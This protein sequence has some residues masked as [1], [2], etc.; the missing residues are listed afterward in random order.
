MC[1]INCLFY[2]YIDTC[3]FVYFIVH[4]SINRPG[5]SEVGGGGGG[6]GVGRVSGGRGGMGGGTSSSYG[7]PYSRVRL[8]Y[9][10]DC[11]SSFPPVTTRRYKEN[12][13]FVSYPH[14]KRRESLLQIQI[15]SPPLP[16]PAVPET[17]R[18]D[19]S[20]DPGCCRHPIYIRHT[21]C[22]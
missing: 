3:T 8:G 5:G 20:S 6:P 14:P 12:E 22:M 1:F 9:L 18:T 16:L 2:K 10:P 21:V 4:R 19:C 11:P 13:M 17:T 7:T 15:P